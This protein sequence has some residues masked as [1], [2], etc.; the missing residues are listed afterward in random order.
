MQSIANKLG[1][2]GQ[3]V[4]VISGNRA[5]TVTFHKRCEGRLER[6]YAKL[7]RAKERGQPVK[8]IKASIKR[9]EVQLQIL[10]LALNLDDE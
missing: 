10:E 3:E 6:L 5:S 2:Q 1:I 4:R 8:E 9:Y 7:E